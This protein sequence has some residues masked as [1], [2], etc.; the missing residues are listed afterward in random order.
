MKKLEILKVTF[1]LRSDK[2]KT[3]ASPIMMQLYLEGRRAYIGT[4][5]KVEIDQWDNQKGK[6]M[7]AKHPS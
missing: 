5:E 3:G 2:K 4:G 7:G 6:I 1:I